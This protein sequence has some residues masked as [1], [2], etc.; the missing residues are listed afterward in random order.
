MA[1]GR[2]TPTSSRPSDPS[3]STHGSRSLARLSHFSLCF[4][5]GAFNSTRVLVGPY[6]RNN[7]TE[8]PAEWRTI[9]SSLV[10]HPSYTP[11]EKQFDFLAFAIEPVTLPN[12]IPVVLN[13][14]ATNPINGQ[15]MT[16]IGMGKT[17]ND[18]ASIS[19]ILL[20][21]IVGA[22]PQPACSLAYRDLLDI[23]ET[24]MLCGTTTGG[25]DSCGGAFSHKKM[26]P[27]SFRHTVFVCRDGWAFKGAVALALSF[28]LTLAL[29]P[30]QPRRL[31]W[32]SPG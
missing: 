24:S 20:K 6:L 22:V 29:L 5:A 4:L 23:N 18:D 16:V 32:A 3:F 15:P 2:G 8:G 30:H 13:T 14:D 9:T 26:R 21:V 19:D 25:R 1:A 27:E 12:L 10:L 28:S 7:S 31:G 17:T 11:T